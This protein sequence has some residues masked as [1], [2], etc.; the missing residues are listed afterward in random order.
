MAQ[1][2]SSPNGTPLPNE[3][4]PELG[5]QRPVPPPYPSP[6]FFFF[7]K[8]LIAFTLYRIW[9]WTAASGEPDGLS[10]PHGPVPAPQLYTFTQGNLPLPR[11]IAHPPT[12]SHSA[13]LSHHPPT[14]IPSDAWRSAVST[15]HTRTTAPH[16]FQSPRAIAAVGP[17]PSPY[18]PTIPLSWLPFCFSCFFSYIY[19][20]QQSKTYTSC[21]FY[22]STTHDN[23]LHVQNN[24]NVRLSL[25]MIFHVTDWFKRDIWLANISEIGTKPHVQSLF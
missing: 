2:S 22:W 20:V 8:S 13:C 19:S 25:V 10:L 18:T 17:Y 5:N 16:S 3:A 4:Y 12:A 11:T 1:V 6:F 9:R 15:R 24:Q 7:K 21:R 14:D 23:Y